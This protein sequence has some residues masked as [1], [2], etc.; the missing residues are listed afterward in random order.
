MPE[1]LVGVYLGLAVPLDLKDGA[2]KSPRVVSFRFVN[3]YWIVYHHISSAET[4]LERISHLDGIISSQSTTDLQLLIQCNLLPQKSSTR[5]LPLGKLVMPSLPLRLYHSPPILYL[6]ILSFILPPV[7]RQVC[8]T[9]CKVISASSS[10]TAQ[11]FN[12]QH[13][14]RLHEAW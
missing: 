1:T 13:S 2:D 4:C 5:E 3:R 14:T 6:N 9:V 12:L 8:A 7:F 10:L 11:R